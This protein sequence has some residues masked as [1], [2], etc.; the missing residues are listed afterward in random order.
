MINTVIKELLPE[1]VTLEYVNWLKDPTLIKYSNLQYLETNF[2]KQFNYVKA[3]NNSNENM[4]FGIFISNKHIGNILLRSINYNHRNAEVTYLIGNKSFW[5]KG[6]A[7]FALNFISKYAKKELNLYKLY[8]GV[9]EPNLASQRVLLNN[10]FIKE[11]IRNDHL[12]LN[13]LFVNQLDY[14][15]IL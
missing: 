11:G 3:I 13:N 12:F 9:A 7:S 4:L 10:Q 6:Y 15:K 5:S 1:D 8:A 14:G 2:E